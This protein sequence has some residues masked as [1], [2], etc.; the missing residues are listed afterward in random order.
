MRHKN[1]ELALLNGTLEEKVEQRTQALDMSN[2]Q[3]EKMILDLKES[4]RSTARIF[5]NLLS[6]NKNLGGHESLLVGK[7]CSLI[8]KKWVYPMR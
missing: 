4:Q 8:A 7:L 1:D 3:L 5:Y 2:R 6:L